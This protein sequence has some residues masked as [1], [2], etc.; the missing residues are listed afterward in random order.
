MSDKLKVFRTITAA[1]AAAH[2][3]AQ[4][5]V[6]DMVRAKIE[7]GEVASL[8]ILMCARDPEV[9]GGPAPT[10]SRFLVA[11]THLD[12]ID[13]VYHSTMRQLEQQYGI[14]VNQLRAERA[15]SKARG[16]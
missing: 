3:R 15:A 12:I 9:S 1:D 13:D 7:A 11:A 6:L 5:E 14:T 10:S 4:I 16:S 2:M 8:G